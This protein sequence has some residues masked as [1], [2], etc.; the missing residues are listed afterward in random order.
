MTSGPE[1]KRYGVVSHEQR[2]AM[3]GLE[4]VQCLVSGMLPL[5]NMAETLG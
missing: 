5:N 3:S 1:G 2:H 4:F